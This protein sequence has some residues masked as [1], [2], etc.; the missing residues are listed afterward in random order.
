MPEDSDHLVRQKEQK[1]PK[2][3]KRASRKRNS[4]STTRRIAKAR[5]A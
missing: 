1:K 3:H 4:P 2:E 5:G